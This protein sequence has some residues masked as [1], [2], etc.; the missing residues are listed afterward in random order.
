MSMTDP[1]RD[2]RW[3]PNS[4]CG[5]DD[6]SNFIRCVD[7]QDPEVNEVW[8]LGEDGVTPEVH[9]TARFDVDAGVNCEF[10]T[11]YLTK[12]WFNTYIF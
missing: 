11:N 10:A 8:I 7:R 1:V 9:T 6:R 2:T 4:G 5:D 12:D 3:T